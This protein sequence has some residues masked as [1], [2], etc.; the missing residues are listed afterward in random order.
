MPKKFLSVSPSAHIDER[1]L[2]RLVS[3]QIM[4]N[5]HHFIY[6]LLPKKG[7]VA[8]KHQPSQ[9]CISEPHVDRAI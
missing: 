7:I 9:G 3:L 2:Y 8:T 6:A 5:F 1:D 4:Y